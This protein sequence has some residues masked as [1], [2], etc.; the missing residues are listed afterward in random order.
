ME[1]RQYLSLVGKW[2]WLIVLSVVIAGGGSYLASRSATPLYRTKTTLMVGRATQNPDPNTA[3]MYTGQQLAYTYTQLVRREPVLN[4]AIEGLDLQMSWEALSNRVSANIIAQTQLLEISVIDSDPY[5]AKVLADAI[6]Q[7]LIL[8]SPT[9]T[10]ANTQEEMAF[11]KS[12]LSEL[13]NKVEDGQDEVN[14]L[15][16]ELDAAN[17]ASQIQNLQNQINVLE[18]KISGWQSTY[19]QLLI[20]LQ[21]GDVNALTVIEEATVPST[22]ISPNVKMNVLLASVIGIILAVGGVFL[23]EYLDDTIKT[24]EDIE[25]TTK[26]PALGAIARI[27]GKGYPEKLIALREPLAPSVEL[28]RS[29]RTNIQYSSV[30]K[31]VRTFLMTGPGPSEG[32]S[33]CL[34]NLG[35]VMAQSNLKVIVVDADLRRPVQH[36]IF[37][38]ANGTGLSDV[39]LHPNSGV[40]EYLQTTEMDNLRVLTSG[41]LP[42]NPAEL[43]G[44]ERMKEIIEELKAEA[45]I[46]L[47]DSPPSLVVA[48]AVILSTRVDGVIMINDVGHTR[49]NEARRAAEEMRRVQANL[50][51]VVLNRFSQE[52]NGYYYYYQKD[53]QKEKKRKQA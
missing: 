30:N 1:L 21:G 27:E 7:Q 45:D 2:A 51:G 14:R 4:G 38:L 17:S 22:P 3:D 13:K 47:F 46:V 12:Q 25:R 41:P 50:L 39:I 5:R 43:L 33:V 18:T 29:L 15:K 9:G 52:R 20:S 26:L 31:N 44:S 49:F 11:I 6:A 35:V 16:Q 36:E 23:I 28:Y 24:L 37:G 19:S 34:A 10:S 40:N 53:S 42:P 32:K 8:Q 48:D